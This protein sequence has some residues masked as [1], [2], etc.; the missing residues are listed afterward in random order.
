MTW[1]LLLDFPVV[2][3]VQFT[4]Y[5]VNLAFILFGAFEFALPENV[6]QLVC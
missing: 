5:F 1:G 3:A 6:F 4:S 2:F